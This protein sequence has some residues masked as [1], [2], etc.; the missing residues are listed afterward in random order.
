MAPES[1]PPCPG[2]T[3]TVRGP[4]D[5]PGAW[6]DEDWPANTG[7]TVIKV[8]IPAKAMARAGP[9]GQRDGLIRLSLFSCVTCCEFRAPRRRWGGGTHLGERAHR[10]M[11][12]TP[13]SV[14]SPPQSLADPRAVCCLNG[15]RDVSPRRRRVRGRTAQARAYARKRATTQQRAAPPHR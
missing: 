10:V 4:C 14:V 9:S 3:H 5:G 15:G 13:P 12:P 11:S 6:P 1:L 8:S 7:A 2:S